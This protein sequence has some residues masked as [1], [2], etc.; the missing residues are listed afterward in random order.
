[1]ST[2]EFPVT[3]TPDLDSGGFVVTFADVPEAI[4]QGDDEAEALDMA[5]DALITSMDFYFE[6]HRRVPAPSSPAPGQPMVALPDELAQRVR[7]HNDS[8]QT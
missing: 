4:T 8:L 7:L 3:L 2:L 1:M 5:K 6:D